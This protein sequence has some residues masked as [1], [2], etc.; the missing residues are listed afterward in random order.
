MIHTGQTL[1]FHVRDAR[2]ADEEM[3]LLLEGETM[4]ASSSQ[5]STGVLLVTCNGRGTRLFDK[6]HHDVALIRQILGDIPIAGFFAAGEMGPV[7]THN[8]VH[9]HTAVLALF[10]QS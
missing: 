4:L 5:Q 6:P 9:G 1:Q 7:G 10:R 2:T 8:F 3:R